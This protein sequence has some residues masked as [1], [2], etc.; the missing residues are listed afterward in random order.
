MNETGSASET[1]TLHNKCV[2]PAV[3]PNPVGHFTSVLPCIT[4]A[5]GVESKSGVK[6]TCYD[7]TIVIPPQ[8][9]GGSSGGST[10]QNDVESQSHCI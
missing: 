5:S 7:S 2:F 6:W 8:L 1:F 3:I 4:E 10:L 9:K